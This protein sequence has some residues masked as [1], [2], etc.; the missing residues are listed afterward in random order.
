MHF[1]I[2][3]S[4]NSKGVSKQA[5]EM[6]VFLDFEF[7]PHKKIPPLLLNLVLRIFLHLNLFKHLCGVV[8]VEMG[9]APFLAQLS[10]PLKQAIKKNYEGQDFALL[11]ANCGLAKKA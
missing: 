4:I 9:H 3:G 6:I 11:C 10:H 5:Y 2:K 7:T 1:Y 8:G